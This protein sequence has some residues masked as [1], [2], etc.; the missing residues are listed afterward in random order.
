MVCAS[1][2]DLILGMR[3]GNQADMSHKKLGLQ[4]GT[5]CYSY[6]FEKLCSCFAHACEMLEKGGEAD[7]VENLT[8]SV[9]QRV[10]GLLHF[11]LFLSWRAKSVAE[12][13]LWVCCQVDYEVDLQPH[14]SLEPDYICPKVIV[15]P[16][17]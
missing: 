14:L 13:H 4:L 1:Q 2:V 17:P 8:L 5:F 16:L 3:N 11:F 10:L 15:A 12:E 9:K 6:N 7:H